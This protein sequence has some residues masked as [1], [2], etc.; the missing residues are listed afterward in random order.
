MCEAP[1][2]MKHMLLIMF[3]FIG[4]YALVPPPLSYGKSLPIVRIGVVYDGPHSDLG[5]GKFIR[6]GI[7]QKE[8]LSLTQGEF[9]VQ[10]PKKFQ[11][12][13]G[14]SAKKVD[15]ALTALLQQPAGRYDSDLRPSE[16]Q[17]G[18]PTDKFF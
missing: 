9:H 14:W 11:I 7:I 18:A 2:H 15:R 6:Q 10:F 4:F 3:A 1:Q 8:I 17:R 16:H 13:G 12:H 5:L